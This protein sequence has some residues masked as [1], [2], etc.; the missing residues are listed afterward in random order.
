MEDEHTVKTSLE[1]VRVLRVFCF[2]LEEGDTN[3]RG[4]VNIMYVASFPGCTT[5]DGKLGGAW[6]QGYY[7]CV[8][9]RAG[10]PQHILCHSIVGIKQNWTSLYNQTSTTCIT[11][12]CVGTLSY[13]SFIEVAEVSN[14]ILVR[15]P[16]ITIICEVLVSHFKK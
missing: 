8:T 11:A 10:D 3:N 2:S 14:S 4:Q 12:I 9:L 5:S 16:S 7:V 6:E 1:E 15:L 13:F